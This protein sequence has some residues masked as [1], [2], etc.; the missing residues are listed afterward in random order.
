MIIDTHHH[1]WSYKSDDFPWIDDSICELKQDFLTDQLKTALIENNINKTIVVQARQSI[2]ETEFLLSQAN[3][4]DFIAG[5]IGWVDLK[6][7]QLEE[8]LHHFMHSKYFKGVRHVLHDEID[9]DYILNESFQ[10]G[11]SCLGDNNLIYELLIF[12]KHLPQVIKTVKAHPS[13]TFVLNHIAKP[14]IKN[15]SH[16]TWTKDIKTLGQFP[17]VYVKM[18]GM[19]TE[20]T[21]KKWQIQDFYYYLDT[22]Y[23]AFGPNRVMFGSDWPVCL[24]S[25]NYGDV[26][27]IIQSWSSKLSDEKKDLLFFK[28]AMIC[29][30]IE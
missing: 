4:T 23:D 3:D 10:S 11:L 21:Y 13:V 7:D 2:E 5:V 28:N 18:S 6:S 17:N 12:P 27:N 26:L 20:V 19:V 14:D 1:L 16:D 15:N 22:V 29:Y 24:L 30:G 8:T 25:A 9:D